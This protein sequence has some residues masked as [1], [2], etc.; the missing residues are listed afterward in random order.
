LREFIELLSSNEVEFVLIG[1]HAVAFH[2]Y[3]R[4]TLDADFLVRPS[5]D[6]AQRVVAALQQFGFGDVG[7]STADFERPAQVIQLGVPPNRIDILTSISGVSFDEVWAGRVEIEIDGLALSVIGRAEL[8]HNKRASGKAARPGGRRDDRAARAA[9]L[10][11][12]KSWPQKSM[13]ACSTASGGSWF[14]AA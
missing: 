13:S 4:L 9:A 7:L 6:N 5:P 2:G 1:G 8:L 14:S 10:S 12:R 11:Y 3:P